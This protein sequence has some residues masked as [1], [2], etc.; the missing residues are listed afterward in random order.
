[1]LK[2]ELANEKIYYLGDGVYADFSGSYNDV[3]LFTRDKDDNR[4][5]RIFLDPAMIHMLAQLT[6]AFFKR[7]I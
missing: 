4:Q 5:M 2:S 3:Q 1:M 6:K 7:E